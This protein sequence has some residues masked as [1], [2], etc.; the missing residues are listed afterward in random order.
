MFHKIS[1]LFSLTFLFFS[2]FGQSVLTGSVKSKIDNSPISGAPVTILNLRDSSILAQVV[3]GNNGEFRVSAPSGFLIKISH[4]NYVDRLFIHRLVDTARNPSLEITLDDAAGNLAEVLIHSEVKLVGIKNGNSVF[5]VANNREFKT[6]ANLL[7]VFRNIPGIRVDG[8]GTLQIGSNVTPTV[9][10]DG[11]PMLLNNQEL[12]NYLKSLTP[13]K[14]ASLEVITNPSARYDGEYKGII[15][16]KLKRDQTMGFTGSYNA[17][18]EQ[19]RFTNME[20]NLSLAY[21]S[22]RFT[23]Y[24]QLGYASG[25]AIYRYTAYQH[26]A[27]TDILSTEL[28]Q[29]NKQNNYNLQAGV[30]FVPNQKNKIGLQVRNY[31]IVNDRARV[32][33]LLST[34][35]TGQQSRFDR[36]SNNPIQYGQNN[37]GAIFNYSLQ[38]KPLKVEVLGNYLSVENKQ[39]DDFINKERANDSLIQY[40]KSD[41]LNKITVYTTQIDLSKKI[42]NISLEGGVKFSSSHTNNNIRYDSLNSNKEFVL[43][44]ERSN[45]FL[46]KEKIKAMYI[47]F[48]GKINEWQ[49]TAG[50][51]AEQTDAVSN[52]VTIDSLVRRNYT[53]W[54]PSFSATYAINEN[55]ELTASYTSRIARPNFSQLNPF[56]FYNS[57]LNY[58]IGNPYLLPA[59]TNQVKI[60]YRNKK[61]LLELNAGREKDVLAR[62]PMYDSTTN[63]LAYLGQ[64]LPQRRFA[65]LSLSFPVTITKWWQ[66][67]YQLMGFYNKEQTPYLDNVYDL[68]VYNYN[69]RLNQ[70]FTLPQKIMAS[71]LA[72]YESKTGNSLYIIK[73]RYN[74]SLDIQRSWLQGKL[75]TKLS[76]NDIFNGYNQYLIFRHKEIINN[77]LSHW[78]GAQ[79]VQL[80]LTYNFGKSTSGIKKTNVSEEENRATR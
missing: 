14:V 16:I 35:K 27:N 44:P 49:F 77:Q 72:N 28:Q 30:D 26:L 50:I 48:A 6:A 18:L 78:W 13:D 61:F 75:N 39:K 5:Q 51:R 73:S 24:S 11:K 10:I 36:T 42:K 57:G 38:L 59:V 23:Y 1:F 64:N 45:I 66:T 21:Q 12:L 67:S 34:D 52:S 58:W 43:D 65:N 76:F 17:L 29:D 55:Q 3:T 56:R 20:N 40:W 46:Y 37:Y 79:R 8:D 53:N 25:T 4:I 54:L 47:S 69:I 19:N 62:Y 2:A 71:L 80:N 41:L 33:H 60:L 32:G 68:S 63:E 15:D 9:F 7:D 74:V 22:K 31:H 70:T